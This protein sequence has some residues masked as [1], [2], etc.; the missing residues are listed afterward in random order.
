[1][2]KRKRQEEK[3][4][5]SKMEETTKNTETEEDKLKYVQG[6]P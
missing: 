3:V 4:K 6:E 5:K 1:L 2:S